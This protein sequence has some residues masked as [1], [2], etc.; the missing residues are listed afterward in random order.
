MRTAHEAT[1]GRRY[2]EMI[3]TKPMKRIMQTAKKRTENL[4][5]IKELK[6][7]ILMT[8]KELVLCYL[9]IATN[10]ADIAKKKES[11]WSHQPTSVVMII[12]RQKA[13]L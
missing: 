2:V 9:P 6:W 5:T 1:N 13:K 3:D 7:A 11:A 10:M 4:K 12:T 8:G